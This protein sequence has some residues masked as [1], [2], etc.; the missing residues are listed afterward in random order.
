MDVFSLVIRPTGIRRRSPPA[1]L[2]VLI[3]AAVM[4]GPVR[5]AEFRGRVPIQTPGPAA[6][7]A[8]T[9]VEPVERQI[10]ERAVRRLFDAYGSDPTT[11]EGFLGE[12]LRDRGRLLDTLAE[13]LPRD[14]RLKALGIQSAQTLNQVVQTDPESGVAE[15]VST[16]AVVVRSQ[17]EFNEPTRGFQRLEGTIEYLLR[18]REP[19]R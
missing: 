3:A 11:L 1:F 19:A 9:V 5:A 6:A 4:A 10:V 7:T 18:V 17:L 13:R 16:V 15:R 2:A 12:G 14:A 8:G